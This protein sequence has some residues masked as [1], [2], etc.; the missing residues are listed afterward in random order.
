MGFQREINLPKFLIPSAKWQIRLKSTSDK[1]MKAVIIC[2]A[3]LFKDAL[4]VQMD[5]LVQCEQACSSET[6]RI[7]QSI[8]T[9]QDTFGSYTAYSDCMNPCL[10]QRVRL[11]DSSES[12]EE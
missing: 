9:A 4:N 12:S 2:F 6:Q 10:A 3:A 11:P 8:K 7:E 1:N 5:K